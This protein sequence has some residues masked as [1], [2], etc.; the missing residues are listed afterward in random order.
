MADLTENY[1]DE[2]YST[3]KVDL[4][5]TLRTNITPYTYT[6]AEA[7][8]GY[9]N[10]SAQEIK[11]YKLDCYH[12]GTEGATTRDTLDEST[13]SGYNAHSYYNSVKGLTGAKAISTEDNDGNKDAAELNTVVD[14][15]D[16]KQLELGACAKLNY[17]KVTFVI[18][19]SGWDTA[20]FD[21]AIMWVK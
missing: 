18:Y 16:N 20:C 5:R 15:E 8:A 19:E 2:N 7:K 21:A 9:A 14:S 13:A 11:S 6:V 12:V 1:K 17:L 10:G 3:Y 4:I